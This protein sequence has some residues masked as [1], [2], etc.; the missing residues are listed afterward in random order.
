MSLWPTLRYIIR[1][2]LFVHATGEKPPCQISLGFGPVPNGKL[3]E[4]IDTRMSMSG[5][6]R[7]SLSHRY[8]SFGDDRNLAGRCWVAGCVRSSSRRIA[9]VGR[10]VLLA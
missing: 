2:F 5:F 8:H 3:V 7:R 10:H 9:D 6:R 4:S 1:Y